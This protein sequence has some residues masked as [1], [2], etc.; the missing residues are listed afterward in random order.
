MCKNIVIVGTGAGGATA[1]RDL[2]LTKNN[3]VMLEK[4]HHYQPGEAVNH[5]INKKLISTSPLS[6]KEYSS[7]ETTSSIILSNST[8]IENREI[9]Q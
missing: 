5:I 4:G 3:V 6:K 7:S 8:N 9:E 1:A 2:S